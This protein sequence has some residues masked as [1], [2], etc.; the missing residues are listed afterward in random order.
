MRSARAG[1]QTFSRNCAA[2]GAQS[3]R[4]SLHAARDRII[5]H[6]EAEGD[7]GCVVLS[8]SKKDWAAELGLTHEALYRALSSMV[9]SGELRVEGRSVSILSAFS[10]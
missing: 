5:R 1:P 7:K 4:L 8:Q 10:V 3:E 6:I 2:S 9:R